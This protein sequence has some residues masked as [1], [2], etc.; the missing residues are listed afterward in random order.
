[1]PTATDDD[2]DID[3]DMMFAALSDRTR[4]AIVA[5]LAEG[6]RTVNEL[7]EPFAISL[8]AV[9]KHIHVLEHAGL[10]SRRR[11]QQRRPCHL[12]VN[13]LA[14]AADWISRYREIWADRFDKLDAHLER[15]TSPSAPRSTEGPRA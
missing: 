7:A 15:L 4:R 9:S 10:V 12:E 2:L 5:R 1:M 14:P 8:Q 13:R 3:L 11:E 6:D